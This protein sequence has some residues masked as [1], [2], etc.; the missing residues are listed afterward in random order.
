MTFPPKVWGDVLRRLQEEIPEFA[1]RAW[2]APLAIKR[3]D[4][5]LLLGC[6]SSFHRDRVRAQY[7]EA[8]ERCL[9]LT[10]DAGAGSAQN[11]PSLLELELA[12]MPAFRS[13]AGHSIEVEIPQRE[14]TPQTAARSG[15]EAIGRV[16]GS[17]SSAVASLQALPQS[18]RGG[19]HGAGPAANPRPP[20][21]PAK[22]GQ[23]EV[24]RTDSATKARPGPVARCS[25]PVQ[26]ELPFSFES[27]VV[28]PCNALAREAV[29]ALARNRQRTLN[30][31]YLGAEA[32]MGKTHLARA[33]AAEARRHAA[34]GVRGS[35]VVYTSAEQF[36]SE[37]VSAMRGGRSEQFKRRYR[38]PID[39]L[40]VEDVQFFSGRA[41]TQLELFHTVQHVLSAGGRVLLTGDRT[42][43]ELSGLDDRMR[44]QVARC[45]VAEID[46]PDALVRRNILRAKAAAGGF[47]L[48]KDCLELLVETTEGSVRD[49]ESVL[50][51]VVTTASLTGRTIDLELTREAV[52]VKSVAVGGAPR[53]S[54]EVAEIVR[55]VAAFFGK[56]PEALAS[57]SRRRDV[58]VPR[59]LAMYLAHR[60]TGASLAEIGRA[61]GRDHPSVRNAIDRIERQVLENA[62]IRYQVEGLSERIDRTLERETE[63]KGKAEDASR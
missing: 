5:R 59:Q 55:I 21:R 26:E 6:P 20:S 62:P 36:T 3:A 28:G 8:I 61:L 18:R 23:G 7:L 47:R 38:G 45:F 63:G 56:R 52:D 12:L 4:D 1:F 31:I 32:G 49:I 16:G 29:L 33:A 40:V 19:D 9:R 24:L 14:A 50:I 60:Y 39:L 51:Q 54:I 30:Q 11:T 37:F 43:R 41:K 46:R 17:T 58:L 27:F 10:L 2:I 34:T 42:P 48:P 44:G 53:R 22:P 57:R 35:S 13:A 15:E 25:E